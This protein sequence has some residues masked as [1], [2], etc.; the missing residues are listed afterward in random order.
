V[1]NTLVK[2]QSTAPDWLY[3]PANIDQLPA[4][5]KE[6][7]KLSVITRKD[8]L[9]PYTSTFV[10]VSNKDLINKTCPVLVQELQ[11]LKLY[12]T[13]GFIAL[14]SVDCSKEFPPH[15]DVGDDIAVNI[16]LINCEGT[17]TVWYRAEIVDKELPK[18]AIGSEIARQARVCDPR[19][20]VEIGRCDSSIPHWINVNVPH[21]PETHHDQLRLAASL[22][23]LPSPLD[24]KGELWP[25]LIK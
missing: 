16:P 8:N 20:A 12:D 19:T 1:N 15:V 3:Y 17:Y 25:H 5:Q 4:V 6:L 22:R 11:R 18:Y 23:F 24:E 21:R 14:I 9:V 7:I 2:Y 10:E 13:L